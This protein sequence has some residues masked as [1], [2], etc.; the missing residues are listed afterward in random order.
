[1][2]QLAHTRAYNRGVIAM[3]P[4][5]ARWRGL[6]VRATARGRQLDTPLGS[7]RVAL[8][9]SAIGSSPKH[10]V[11]RGEQRVTPRRAAERSVPLRAANGATIST[12]FT[13]AIFFDLERQSEGRLGGRRPFSR[14][15]RRTKRRGCSRAASS[16]NAP[17]QRSERPTHRP[18]DADEIISLTPRHS[19]GCSG[20]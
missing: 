10:P 12:S 6:K 4:L 17:E 2:A 20:Q 7:N 19:D 15:Q 11:Q 5:K 3:R 14:T 16:S 1:M 9:T 8:T 18:V 13:S